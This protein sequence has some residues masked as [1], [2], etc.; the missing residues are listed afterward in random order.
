ML[1]STIY[2]DC[3]ANMGS[4]YRDPPEGGDHKFTDTTS[5]NGQVNYKYKRKDAL[6]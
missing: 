1:I 5:T 3:N 6:N 4:W 2:L